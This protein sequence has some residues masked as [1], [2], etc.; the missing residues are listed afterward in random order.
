[1]RGVSAHNITIVCPPVRKSDQRLSDAFRVLEN[2]LNFVCSHIGNYSDE[3]SFKKKPWDYIFDRIE[4]NPF[5]RMKALTNGE[6]GSDRV[7]V[8]VQ[9]FRGGADE[10]LSHVVT[11]QVLRDYEPNTLQNIEINLIK[12]LESYYLTECNPKVM[13]AMANP[14]PSAAICVYE[15][16]RFV[17]AGGFYD[18]TYINKDTASRYLFPSAGD[19]SYSEA[20]MTT[21][22]GYLIDPRGVL[23]PLSAENVQLN[24][25]WIRMRFPWSTM[26]DALNIE[27]RKA[28]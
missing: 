24:R 9:A 4:K 6:R 11:I 12:S 15:D 3:V 14:P 23:K 18:R 21:Q 16:I 7:E 8:V 19:E 1:M 5:A 22:G 20:F 26:E 25:Q 13:A 2:D 27:K 28:R 17:Y 10:V